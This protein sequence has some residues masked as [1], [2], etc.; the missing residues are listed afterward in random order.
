MLGEDRIG[1]NWVAGSPDQFAAS[2]RRG[3]LIAGLHFL[4]WLVPVKT[5]HP[6]F[7]RS[8]DMK[9]GPELMS[10]AHPRRLPGPSPQW[11]SGPKVTRLA[12]SGCLMRLTSIGDGSAKRR[13]APGDGLRARIPDRAEFG[14]PWRGSTLPSGGAGV[15]RGRGSQ[16]H[17][18]VTPFFYPDPGTPLPRIGKPLAARQE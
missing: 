4:H 9:G 5:N 3:P 10:V 2:N 13:S 1:G 6:G 14:A 12:G 18:P 16:R 15:V 17:F 8:S 11:W 7:W